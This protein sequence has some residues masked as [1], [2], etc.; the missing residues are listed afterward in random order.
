MVWRG[1]G[2]SEAEAEVANTVAHLFATSSQAV[3][4]S[5]AVSGLGDS[6]SLLTCDTVATSTKLRS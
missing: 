3:I 6:A 4:V 1:Q 5:V 2:A